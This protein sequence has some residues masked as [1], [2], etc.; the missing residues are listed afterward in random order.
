MELVVLG[1][2]KTTLDFKKGQQKVL[3]FQNVF[4]H[5]IEH[6][7]IVPDYWVCGDP[8]AY[9]SGLA[10]LNQNTDKEALK[11][12]E[13]LVPDI[14]TKDLSHYRKYCGSTPLMRMMGG[15]NKL[16]DLL[17]SSAEHYKVKIF[18]TTT[19]KYIKTFE[20]GTQISNLFE[21]EYLR[22][23]SEKVVFG[24]V[25]FDNES[26]IGDRF[27]WGLENKLTSV[28]LPVAYHLRAKKVK[29]YGFDYRGPRFYSAVTRHPWNDETQTG[30]SSVEFSLS[31]L[32]KWIEW[33]S[34]HGMKIVSGTR[35]PISLPNKFLEYEG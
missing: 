23:M 22:F 17:S 26:V 28:A 20:N 10:L 11:N 13:I 18:P 1:P 3:A 21:E 8:Y 27:K 33:E 15:W 24:T 30:N 14:F 25:E 35:D 9:I 5:C 34:T 32:Q 16:Q 6:L 29:V 2:G 4:P 19:T 7:G 12:I 31:L